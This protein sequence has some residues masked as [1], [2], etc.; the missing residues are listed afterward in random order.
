MVELVLA[1]CP[2]FW[3]M[4]MVLCRYDSTPHFSS[5]CGFLPLRDDPNSTLHA[6][7]SRLRGGC[8]WSLISS[9]GTYNLTAGLMWKISSNHGENLRQLECQQTRLPRFMSPS[10]SIPLSPTACCSGRL[11]AAT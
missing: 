2:S 6:T 10:F 1:D 5:F 4:R 8:L 11:T 9:V 7:F 3:R